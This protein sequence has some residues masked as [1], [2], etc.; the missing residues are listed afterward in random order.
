MGETLTHGTALPSR[1]KSTREALLAEKRTRT[2]ARAAHTGTHG[3]EPSG[4]HGIEQAFADSRP[5]RI[6]RSLSAHRSER[7]GD[8]TR[9]GHCLATAEPHNR[10]ST[11]DKML[12]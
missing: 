1:R 11:Q 2:E 5:C 7:L 10:V 12:L 9:V 6:V 8:R 3:N 4:W